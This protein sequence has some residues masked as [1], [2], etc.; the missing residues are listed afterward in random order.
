ME[1]VTV[2][3]KVKKDLWIKIKKYNVN[4]SRVIRKAL[5]E[6][7]KK[8]EEE[9]LK[10]ELAKASDILKKIPSERIVKHIREARET[11]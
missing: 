10:K 1:T 7:V 11:H 9:E 2:S 8:R 5:E 6:E 3:A 4:I